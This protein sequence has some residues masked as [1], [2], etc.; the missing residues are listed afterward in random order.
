MV[1][2]DATWKGI[3]ATAWIKWTNGSRRKCS[4]QG[5]SSRSSEVSPQT[6]TDFHRGAAETQS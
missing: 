5:T 4:K 2:C 3:S 6:E 1:R